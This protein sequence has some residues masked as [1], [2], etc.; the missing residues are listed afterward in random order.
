[1]ERKRRRKYKEGG[2]GS[3]FSR[4]NCLT[5]GVKGVIEEGKSWKRKACALV[6]VSVRKNKGVWEEKRSKR[7]ALYQ[8]MAIRR[9]AGQSKEGEKV[10]NRY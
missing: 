7:R 3:P 10:H 2:E 8:A 9:Q 5:K 1:M 4:V 6:L